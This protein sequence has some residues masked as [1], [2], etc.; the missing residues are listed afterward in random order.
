[1][2]VVFGG[3]FIMDCYHDFS[4][5][6]IALGEDLVFPMDVVI[7]K[8]KAVFWYEPDFSDYCYECNLVTLKKFLEF[9]FFVLN[10]G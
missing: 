5:G 7:V 3:D 2:Y 1:M 6:R 10:A 8:V 4:S 9:W